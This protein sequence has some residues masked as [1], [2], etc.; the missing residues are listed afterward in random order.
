MPVLTYFKRLPSECFLFCSFPHSRS[1]YWR[2]TGC[3]EIVAGERG[4]EERHSPRP[5]GIGSLVE[6]VILNYVTSNCKSWWLGRGR[7]LRYYGGPDLWQGPSSELYTD[8]PIKRRSSLVEQCQGA[9]G[10]CVWFR[11]SSRHQRESVSFSSARR[12][13]YMDPGK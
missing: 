12:K 1:F 11:M 13:A 6:G 7:H 3:L 10:Q 5:H 2:L 9:M 4:S 8:T